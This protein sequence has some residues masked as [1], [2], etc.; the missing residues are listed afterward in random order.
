MAFNLGDIFVT[1]KAK[2]DSL[3]QGISAVKNF[4][5]QISASAGNASAALSKIGSAGEKVVNVLAI[6]GSAATF[7]AVKSAADFEQSRIAFDTMLGSAEKGAKMMKT[8]SEFARKTP[9][10]L[11][12][13]VEGAKKLLAYNIEAEKIIPTLKMLG[14][15]SAGVGKDKLPQLILAFG[16]VKAATFLTGM[17]L[18]QFTEA[19]VPLLDMLAK[20]SGKTAAQI[21]QD[22]ESGVRI[23]FEDVE[24]ALGS[25]TGEGGKF[26]NL[27]ERQSQ[28]FSGVMS[29]VK[30]NI[31]RIARE[32]VGI[33]ESGDIREGSLFAKL[34]DGAQRL[35]AWMDAHSADIEKFATDT[36]TKI[37]DGAERTATAIGK[38]VDAFN[39]LP[40]PVKNAIGNIGL[41]AAAIL[42]I[43]GIISKLAPAFGVLAAMFGLLTNPITIII[44]LFALV[45]L[46]AHKLV[47]AWDS[48]SVITRGLAMAI[49]GPI[50]IAIG[51]FQ[52][53]KDGVGTAFDWIKARITDVSNFFAQLPGKIGS[54]L[55]QIPTIVG[56]IIQSI[57][58]WFNQLP[59]MI[60]FAIGATIAGI[61]NGFQSAWNFITQVL[62]QIIGTVFAWFSQLPGIIVSFVSNAV[63]GAIN[64]FNQLPG[65]I[66]GAVSAA[67]HHAVGWFNHLRGTIINIAA[68]AVNNVV[69]WFSGLPGRIVSAISGLG[70][71]LYEKARSM[72]ADFWNGFKK[73]LGIKSPSYVEK[74][75]FKIRDTALDTVEGMKTNIKTLNT[76]ASGLSKPMTATLNANAVGIMPTAVMMQSSMPGMSAQAESGKSVKNETN[77]NG[78]INIAN[79]DDANYLLSRLDRNNQLETALGLSPNE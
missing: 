24:R 59:G 3:Q 45:G 43:A 73:G 51:L 68:D 5:N 28:S 54:F 66:A 52:T 1:I 69:G 56:N 10:E 36:L 11:P 50:T 8:L 33:S 17:E 31:G 63:N 25:M 71:Q 21:K 62:P 14:N 39:K 48:M 78:D 13:V 61:I 42:P 55:S 70:G 41:L 46:A 79:K 4:E 35:L 9:F 30:D 49:G 16:Q 20:Q 2:T 74:A 12:E 23:P 44:G 75:L 64:W 19:G 32:I 27:M 7:F 40:E 72:A 34:R 76:M 29:N 67:F 53:L 57:I 18:R 26:F 22:M 38:I 60:G 6:A 65:R 15:I 37:V 47:T 58:N 77:I